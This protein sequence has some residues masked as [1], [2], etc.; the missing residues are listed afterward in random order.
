MII[1]RRLLEN[2]RPSWTILRLTCVH[3]SV[4]LSSKAWKATADTDT[5]RAECILSEGKKAAVKWTFKPGLSQ[6]ICRLLHHYVH[7]SPDYFQRQH[8]AA[9]WAKKLQLFKNVP[10]NLA[11][12]QCQHNATHCKFI[13]PE[14][15]CSK[16]FNCFAVEISTSTN[17]RCFFTFGPNVRRDVEQFDLIFIWLVIVWS[18]GAR[19]SYYKISYQIR[20]IHMMQSAK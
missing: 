1:R 7:T 18:S 9:Q 5:T 20:Q 8:N 17:L 10:L 14:T 15:V 12:F 19:G 11:Y 13:W 6:A 16:K 3:L 2:Q 4:S